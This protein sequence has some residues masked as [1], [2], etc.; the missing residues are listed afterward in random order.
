MPAIG[1]ETHSFKHSGT[2]KNKKQE[3]IIHLQRTQR[4]EV[5]KVKFKNGKKK[6]KG[7]KSPDTAL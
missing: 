5:I 3:D 2:H 7:R 1:A 4:G 6:I